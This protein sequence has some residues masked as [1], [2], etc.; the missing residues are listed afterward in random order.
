VGGIRH[1]W[2]SGAVHPAGRGVEPWRHRQ[3]LGDRS[4]DGKLRDCDVP[5]ALVHGGASSVRA[6]GGQG[7]DPSGR[8]SWPVGVRHPLRPGRRLATVQLADRALGTS[9]SGTQFF[10]ER[11]RRLGHILDPRTGVPAEGVLSATVVAPTAAEAD[12]LSTALYVLGPAGLA[13][14]APA[15]G[16]VGAILVVPGKAAGAVRCSRPTSPK[17]CSRSSRARAWKSDGAGKRRSRAFFHPRDTLSFW[18]LPYP[19]ALDLRPRYPI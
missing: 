8:R 2:Q 10:I 5:S 1:G 11:G 12:S 13:R 18:A 16:A 7:I 15:G 9:G 3:R 6:I 19:P 17:T 14:V 4:R